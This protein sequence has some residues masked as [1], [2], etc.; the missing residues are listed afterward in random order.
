MDTKFEFD[1]WVN[2]YADVVFERIFNTG[3]AMTS[4]IE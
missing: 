4:Q 1:T 3:I 2:N